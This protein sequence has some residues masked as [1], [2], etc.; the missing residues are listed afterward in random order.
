MLGLVWSLIRPLVMLAIYYFIMGKV[1][2]LNRGIDN[3]AVFIYSGLAL[4]SLFQ[5]SVAGGT[6]SI[7]ANSGII[8]KTKLP[9]EIMPLTSI[10]VALFNFVIQLIILV[11]FVF[12][13]KGINTSVNFLHF[14]LAIA[15]IV[16]WATA[17]ALLLSA[18]NVYLR[19]IQYLTEVVLMI[20]FY[21]SPIIY[22]WSMAAPALGPVL[23]DIY[24]LNPITLA[25]MGTQLVMWNHTTAY[26]WPPFLAQRLLIA[27]AVGLVFLLIASRVFDHLQRNFAQEI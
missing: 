22:P 24:L 16:V 25:V 26:P 5:E 20:G 12:A 21:A 14:P 17:F 10:G 27:L 18:A 8:K 15:V 7:V 23:Q 11:V 4:W 3:F 1:L 19:D 2:G 6:A 13:T 9:R